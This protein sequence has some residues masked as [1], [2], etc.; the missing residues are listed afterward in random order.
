MK[1]V[2]IFVIIE[3]KAMFK[4]FK[5]KPQLSITFTICSA[6]NPV[7]L[8]F[9]MLCVNM[10]NLVLYIINFFILD[11]FYFLRLALNLRF[12]RNCETLILKYCSVVCTKLKDF[13]TTETLFIYNICVALDV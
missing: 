3:E 7:S 1:P 4:I 9:D 12:H 2:S 6:G 11:I 10:S 8:V 5:K 13:W